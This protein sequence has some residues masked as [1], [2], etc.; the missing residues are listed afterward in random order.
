M[1]LG[2][3]FG[4]DFILESPQKLIN[5]QSV[6][7]AVEEYLEI[8]KNVETAGLVGPFRI[9]ATLYVMFYTQQI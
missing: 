7:Q 5:F 1:P 3:S 4:A 8:L 2:S 9:V 6:S